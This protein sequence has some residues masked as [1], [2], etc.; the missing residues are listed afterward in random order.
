M[1]EII[2]P[3]GRG[4]LLHIDGYLCYKHSENQDRIYWCCCKKDECSAR[5]ITSNSEK[6]I[7]VH[8]GPKNYIHDH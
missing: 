8:K 7:I 5:A 4:K 6:N 1:A 3:N 2:N